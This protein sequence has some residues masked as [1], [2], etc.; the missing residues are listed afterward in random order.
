MRI[1]CTVVGDG[2]GPSEAIVSVSTRDGVEQLVTAKRKLA[3]NQIEVG[4]PLAAEGSASDKMYLVELPRETA[5][6]RWR[7]WVPAADL[8]RDLMAAE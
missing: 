1:K 6:G 7:V 5:S 2:P 8:S 3:Y 4:E